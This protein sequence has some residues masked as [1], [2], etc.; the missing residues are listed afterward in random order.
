MAGIHA[1]AAALGGVGFARRGR[2]RREPCALR[3]SPGAAPRLQNDRRRRKTSGA[4]TVTED[5]MD[6]ARTTV[7]SIGSV[8]AWLGHDH[9]RLDEELRSISASVDDGRM[10]EAAARYAGFELGVLR[11]LRIEEELIFPVFDARSGLADGPTSVLRDEHRHVRKALGIMRGGLEQGDARGYDDGR[12]FFESVLP[13][14]NAK[15][16]H[17]LYPTLDRLL[18]PAERAALIARLDR[19]AAR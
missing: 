12:R 19:E 6:A 8:T 10:A 3:S 14:H 9:D 2:D 18:L 5:A 7:E 17:I 1:L 4:R 13:D 15:E 11:H 16:E